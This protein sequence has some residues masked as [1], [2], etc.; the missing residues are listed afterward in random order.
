MTE[1]L[2]S[3]NYL[4]LA[5]AIF[6]LSLGSFLE[7]RK[8]SGL[9]KIFLLTCAGLALWNFCNFALEER[10][11]TGVLDML[12]SL[13]LFGAM[14]FANGL[15]YFSAAYPEASVGRWHLPNALLFFGFTAAIFLTDSVSTAEIVADEIVYRDG[16]GFYLFAFYLSVLGISA[17]A[18][19]VLSYRR[20]VE[21][22]DKI[23]YYI[24]GVSI[25]S[26]C[27]IVF[28]LVLPSL[29]NYDF[30][31]VGRLGAT[32]APLA[33]F[34]AMTKH[35]FMDVSVII[36]RATSWLL[37]LSVFA[38][39]SLM[40]L[41][42]AGSWPLIQDLAIVLLVV[43]AALFANPAQKF[44]LTTAKR[45][46]VR[47]WYSTEDVFNRLSARIAQ[48]KD[49][50]TIF[51]EVLAVLDDVFELEDSLSI[52]AVRDEEEQ[53]SCYRISG[54]YRKIAANDA[55]I[56]EMSKFAVAM[57]VHKL[58]VAVQERL[59]GEDLRLMK[60]M[61]IL[62][63]HS[64]EYLEGLLV[65]G[66]KSSQAPFTENDM[67]FFNNLIAYVAPLL[68][69]LTPMEK[70]EQLYN[71]SRQRLHESEIQLIRAQKIEA[72]AYATRQCHHEIRTPLNIIRMGIGRIK[73]LEDLEGYRE[74]AREEIDHALSVV[75]ETLAITEVSEQVDKKFAAV[76]I[77]DIVHRCQRLID[78]S[79]YRVV[80]E[81]EELP[82]VKAVPSDIQVVIINLI[83][84]A[85]DAMPD[86][87]TLVFST[88]LAGGMVEV[89]VE[90]TGQG[91]P[92]ELRSR[93]WE[94]Y[95]SGKPTEAGNSS[96]G[97]GWGLTIVN[98]II[99]EH[100]GTINFTSIRNQGT[101]FTFCLPVSLPASVAAVSR[102]GAGSFQAP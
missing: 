32:A 21:Y 35:E 63:F 55:L 40:V 95:V 22:R 94:P 30:L 2:V 80:L 15:L 26:V 84:N 71:E 67:V 50:E 4:F 89:G 86:G 64:P 28:N 100:A 27:A 19:L 54:R 3:L 82:L 14:V 93:V 96:A 81:L 13:Q 65:L 78:K 41:E 85:L 24:I 53:F 62:P 37:V 49:R 56:R 70:L 97:R 39:L 20:H 47:G 17:L 99:H 60:H 72:I 90:D 59:R 68:Y 79:R 36:N 91:I 38:V 31:I 5:N 61:V 66:E 12:V 23:R 16:A 76:D 44:L 73:T 75:E 18:R 11:F 83:H 77:N 1:S 45:K 7:Q 25:F 87:G 10:L 52:V 6:L 33:F 8:K 9:S 92:E 51:R 74:M 43:A 57:Q 29:G 42:L 58:P 88:T 98:R 34:Y 69:R 101:R 48:E 102:G 46:F